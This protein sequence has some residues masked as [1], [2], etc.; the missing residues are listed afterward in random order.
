MKIVVAF[1]SVLKPSDS[2]FEF[3]NELHYNDD[4]KIRYVIDDDTKDNSEDN[5]IIQMSEKS[6]RDEGFWG[7]VLYFPSRASSRD[8]ALYYFCRRFHDF[9]FLWLIED[10]VFIPRSD[11]LYRIDQQYPDIDLLTSPVGF[12]ISAMLPEPVHWHWHH[13][14]NQKMDFPL[15]WSKTMIC[16]IRVSNKYMQML[17]QYVSLKKRLFLDE[18]LFPTLALHNNLTVSTPQEFQHVTYNKYINFES[19][20]NVSN[21]Y[22]PVKDL[23]VHSDW[24]K[25]LKKRHS[26]REHSDTFSSMPHDREHKTHPVREHR[27]NVSSV[28]HI[29]VHNGKISSDLDLNS[30]N[31]VFLFIFPL[32]LFT[33]FILLRFRV[34]CKR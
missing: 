18:A 10:D 4:Y 11:T 1:L 21:L 23:A 6:A 27:Y 9:D 29:R 15:P 19:I 12:E 30:I 7:S 24:R 31:V 14:K 17:D 16:A 34:D 5:R 20:S 2:S 28:P 25:M 8:K 22:H 3:G 32:C 26:I 13:V 33:V